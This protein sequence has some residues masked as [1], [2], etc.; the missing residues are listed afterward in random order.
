[1]RNQEKKK[2][3]KEKQTKPPVYCNRKIFCLYPITLAKGFL[4]SKIAKGKKKAP[5]NRTPLCTP[6]KV[7]QRTT[8]PFLFSLYTSISH[9]ENNTLRNSRTYSKKFLKSRRN[10][11]KRARLIHQ[12]GQIE[13]QGKK[14]GN[15]GK[16]W[17]T[18]GIVSKVKWTEVLRDL[19]MK[20]TCNFHQIKGSKLLGAV[21]TNKRKLGECKSK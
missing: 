18:E 2:K 11:Q 4:Y 13:L 16:L 1:M 17:W 8:D 3:S 19:H 20:E 10:R 12:W 21:Y 7:F 6:W 15:C 14:G 9:E 5:E